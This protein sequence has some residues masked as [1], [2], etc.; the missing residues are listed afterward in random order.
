MKGGI[1]MG[2]QEKIRLFMY[3]C[4][5]FGVAVSGVGHPDSAGEIEKT[6]VFVIPDIRSLAPY[7][8]GIDKVRDGRTMYLPTRSAE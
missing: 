7:K 3:G 1:L 6:S 8:N 2:V 4:N 5:D